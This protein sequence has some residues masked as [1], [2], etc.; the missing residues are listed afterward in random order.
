MKPTIKVCTGKHLSVT[1][2]I[3]NVLKQ[4]NT[5]S[6]LLSNFTLKY[7]IRKVQEGLKLN[8]TLQMPVN[9]DTIYWE[10]I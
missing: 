7:A 1:F 8:G 9:A 4:G 2:P 5:L 6:P 10:I 3:Q